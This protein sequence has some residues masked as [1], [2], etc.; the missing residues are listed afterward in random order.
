MSQPENEKAQNLRTLLEQHWLHCR[1]VETERAWFMNVYALI[2]GGVVTYAFTTD[3][4]NLWPIYFLMAFTIIGL[5]LAFRWKHAFEY[6]MKKVKE[7][8]T[9]LGITVDL[10]IPTNCFWK[11][12]GTRRLFIYFYC[13]VLV[14]LI[15]L[16]ITNR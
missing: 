6:H 9:E 14:G 7:T 10:Q 12:F 5:L 2:T 4:V 1:H 11:I 8:A 13:L 16:A 3:K 15:I